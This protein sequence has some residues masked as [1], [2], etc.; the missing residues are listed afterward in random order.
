MLGFERYQNGWAIGRNNSRSFYLSRH[1]WAKGPKF[2]FEWHNYPKHNRTHFI[3][4]G[5][6]KRD[7]TLWVPDRFLKRVL[8]RIPAYVY[9]KY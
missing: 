1:D 5:V 2:E 4:I 3:S 9:R 8:D 7:Y 6:G